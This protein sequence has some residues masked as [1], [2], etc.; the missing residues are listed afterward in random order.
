[1]QSHQHNS[2][3]VPDPR[4]DSGAQ[5]SHDLSTVLDQG[6]QVPIWGHPP[7]M[8]KFQ[9]YSRYRAQIPPAPPHV[10]QQH[11]PPSYSAHALRTFAPQQ[12][13]FTPDAAMVPIQSLQPVKSFVVST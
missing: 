10:P 2:C 12:M 1:M 8:L 9:P 4:S 11:S 13:A 6:H 5:S 3:Q 7:A